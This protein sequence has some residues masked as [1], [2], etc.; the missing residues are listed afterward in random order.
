M[1]MPA[2]SPAPDHWLAYVA[3]DEVQ[4]V[5]DTA[6][7]AGAQLFH[8]AT[9]MPGMGEFAVLADPSGAAFALWKDLSAPKEA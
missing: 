7:G 3:V 8:G 1:K 6:V 9:V 5:V 2:E 4:P